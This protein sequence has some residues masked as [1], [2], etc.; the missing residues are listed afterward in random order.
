VHV[1]LWQTPIEHAVPS[2]FDGF[3]Q[4]PIVESH[5]PAL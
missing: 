2:G 4:V 1:P 5:V 3:E